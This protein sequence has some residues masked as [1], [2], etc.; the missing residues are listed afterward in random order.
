M[1]KLRAIMVHDN[2]GS[3]PG[4]ALRIEGGDATARQSVCARLKVDNDRTPRIGQVELLVDDNAVVGRLADTEVPG[5]G[6]RLLVWL[7]RAQAACDSLGG[8]TDPV[9]SADVT[10]WAALERVASAARAAR[11]ALQAVVAMASEGS[12]DAPRGSARWLDTC[13]NLDTLALDA[14]ADLDDALK[15]LDALAGT[16]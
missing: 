6:A 10:R 11:R 9:A 13:S 12:A 16:P 7:Q 4:Y 15:D 2:L 1:S 8:S 14:E 5:I 3:L